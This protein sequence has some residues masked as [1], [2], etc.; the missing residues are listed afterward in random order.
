[1]YL[2]VKLQ[3]QN[4]ESRIR[5]LRHEC[6]SYNM[7]R[8]TLNSHIEQQLKEFQDLM[9]IKVKLDAEIAAYREL[10][11]SGESRQELVYFVQIAWNWCT[12]A[13]EH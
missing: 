10:L 9:D 5:E 1:V 7:E 11:E 6:E 8:A 12:C 4:H 2:C 3:N 13:A